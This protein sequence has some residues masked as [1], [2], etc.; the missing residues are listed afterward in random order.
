MSGERGDCSANM[1]NHSL[2]RSEIEWDKSD[3]S[4]RTKTRFRMDLIK[5]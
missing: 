2:V 1:K 4:I 5:K 3:A